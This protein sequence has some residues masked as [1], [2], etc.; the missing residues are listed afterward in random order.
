M[1]ILGA[2]LAGTL[3]GA[4]EPSATIFEREE[5]GKLVE[6]RAVLRFRD[7][8]IAEALG[9]PFKRVTVYKAVWDQGRAQNWVSP[10]QMNAYS[11]KVTGGFSA[12]SIQDLSTA[13]RFIGPTDLHAILA[14][15]C[16]D[17]IKWRAPAQTISRTALSIYGH[18]TFTRHEPIINTIP[19]HILMDMLDPELQLPQMEAAIGDIAAQKIHVERWCCPAS[20]VHQTIYFPDP[21]TPVYRATLTGRDLIIEAMKVPGP[22]HTIEAMEAFGLTPHDMEGDAPHIQSQRFGKIVPLPATIRKRILLQLTLDYGIYSLGRFATWRNILLDDV[23]EDFFKIRAM[24]GLGTY[25]LIRTMN[26]H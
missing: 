24:I 15:M 4:L 21:L 25:D 17:R 2:G 26:H 8:K 6:H 23:Y 18:G 3:A 1:I 13:T 11:R 16:R 10:A 20:D 19:M 12:R 9:I 7:N 22:G 5:E 14:G